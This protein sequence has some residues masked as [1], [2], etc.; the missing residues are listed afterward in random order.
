MVNDGEVIAVGTGCFI[1][2]AGLPAKK[3][4]KLYFMF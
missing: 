2:G 3:G 4:K 1:N